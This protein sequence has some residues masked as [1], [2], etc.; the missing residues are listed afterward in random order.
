MADKIFFVD[1]EEESKNIITSELEKFI[2]DK[3]FNVSDCDFLIKE[4]TERITQSLVKNSNNFKYIVNVVFADNADKGFTQNI[5]ASYDPETDGVISLYYTFEK[6]TC[7][8]NLFILS[9]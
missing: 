6:I 8:V 1:V 4:L 5:G 2:P 9:I 3:T 7:I